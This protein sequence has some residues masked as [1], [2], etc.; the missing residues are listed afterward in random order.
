MVH[1]QHLF[2]CFQEITNNNPSSDQKFNFNH[3][4]NLKTKPITLKFPLILTQKEE[5]KNDKIT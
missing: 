4:T 1:G 5:K 3:K 2:P